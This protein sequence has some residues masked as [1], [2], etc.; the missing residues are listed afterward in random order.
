MRGL[1][2]DNGEIIRTP[3]EDTLQRTIYKMKQ[4]Y[5]TD[6]NELKDLKGEIEQI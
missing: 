5:Q 3:E 2:D 4:T 1:V 6:Y